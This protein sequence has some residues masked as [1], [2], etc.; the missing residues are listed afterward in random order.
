MLGDTPDRAGFYDSL[1]VGCIPIITEISV[2]VYFRHL[3]QGVLWV[4][5][6]DFRNTIVVWP[7]V[8]TPTVVAGLMK[9]LLGE[10]SSGKAQ[11]RRSR[12]LELVD[13]LVYHDFEDWDTTRPDALNLILNQLS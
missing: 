2:D 9:E 10:L 6:A 1:R 3:H 11:A 4:D 8:V 5:E 13:Y 12:L 7:D